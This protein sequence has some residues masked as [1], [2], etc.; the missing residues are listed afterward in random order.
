V[1]RAA[2]IGDRAPRCASEF[3]MALLPAKGGRSQHDTAAQFRLAD[4]DLRVRAFT[5]EGLIGG[6][7]HRHGRGYIPERIEFDFIEQDN[8][9]KLT[10]M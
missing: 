4:R 2:D 7:N 6:R 5:I 1:T 3:R 10:L 8:P 9:S